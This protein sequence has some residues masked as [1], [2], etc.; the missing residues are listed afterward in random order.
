M[1]VGIDPRD[2]LQK[3]GRIMLR[4]ND[5]IDAP[6]FCTDITSAEMVKYGSNVMMATR[7]SLIN[8]LAAVCQGVG[9]DIEQVATGMSL[10][11]RTGNRLRA[12]LGFGGSCLPK[13]LAA[14][15]MVAGERGSTACCLEGRTAGEP[16]AGDVAV[17]DDDGTVREGST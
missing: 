1:V 6:V 14:M 16:A 11:E 5:L 15:I 13:D 3:I 10:D 7:I 17:T 9:A 12:G 2:D 4:L 8:E